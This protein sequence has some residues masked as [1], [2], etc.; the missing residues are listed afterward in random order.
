MRKIQK[1]LIGTFLGG[2]LLGGIGTGV[3]FVEY[4]SFAYAGEKQIGQESLVT[5]ELDFSFHPEKG[6]IKL[7][8]DYWDR[9]CVEDGP[10]LDETVPEGVVR[11]VVTYNPKTIEPSLEFESY[12]EEGQGSG[13]SAESE[14]EKIQGYL[15]LRNYDISDELEVFMEGKDEFLKELKQRQISSY[16][17]AYVTEIKIQVNPNTAPYLI[18]DLPY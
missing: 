5:K 9:K 11:Y 2:I 14:E 4:S 15:L 6:K 8:Y 3:A 16:R 17:V 1:I 13:T 10:E 12:E 7:V 18:H